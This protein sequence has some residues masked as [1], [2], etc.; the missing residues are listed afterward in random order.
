M[1]P[2]ETLKDCA[3]HTKTFFL[4]VSVVIRDLYTYTITHKTHS[5]S[6]FA[7]RMQENY[8]QYETTHHLI[9]R[10][11]VRGLNATREPKHLLIC[12]IFS[13]NSLMHVNISC[14]T[15]SVCFNLCSR[16]HKYSTNCFQC[17]VAYYKNISIGWTKS[18]QTIIIESCWNLWIQLRQG[19]QIAVNF[20]QYVR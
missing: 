6:R 2:T 17:V 19:V 10:W 14:H 3:V 12:Q 5:F 7:V 16:P 8:N 18:K 13:T 15:F 20:G 9:S 1:L 11:N 4:G